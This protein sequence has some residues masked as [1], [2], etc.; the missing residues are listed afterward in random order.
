MDGFWKSFGFLT[1]M[2]YGGIVGKVAAIGI[3]FFLVLCAAIAFGHSFMW[4]IVLCVFAALA[5]LIFILNKIQKLFEINPELATLEGTEIIRYK[6]SELASKNHPVITV[7]ALTTDPELSAPQG[8][9]ENGV[10]EETE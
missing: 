7:T 2:K 8:L 10:D 4:V 9:L 5:G 6:Q 1:K 3:V